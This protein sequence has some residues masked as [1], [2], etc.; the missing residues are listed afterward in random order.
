MH[1]LWRSVNNLGPA[2]LVDRVLL[3]QAHVSCTGNARDEGII[4]EIA[5]TLYKTNSQ[6]C[7]SRL[8]RQVAASQQFLKASGRECTRSG[9]AL[10]GVASKN[11]RTRLREARQERCRQW[12]PTGFLQKSP[13]RWS[14]R[15]AHPSL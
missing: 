3:K 10:P 13:R 15:A 12:T 14:R 9:F 7:D 6:S 8:E 2:P 5:Q 1:T 4:D 11:H